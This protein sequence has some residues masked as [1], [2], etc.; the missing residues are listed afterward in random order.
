M[1]I[2]DSMGRLTLKE[3]EILHR[4]WVDCHLIHGCEVSS[5]SEDIHVKEF[6]PCRLTPLATA[7]CP[8]SQS[9]LAPLFTET[10][11]MPLRIGRFIIL[12]VFL[13]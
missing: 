8:Y 6:A 1:G 5:D 12:L 10:G 7:E 4:A 3:L 11:I 2:E 13:Q 9:S